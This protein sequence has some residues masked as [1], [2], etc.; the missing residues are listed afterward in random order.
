MSKPIKKRVRDEEVNIDHIDIKDTSGNIV[1]PKRRLSG[2]SMSSV[3][4]IRT[5][6]T[7]LRKQSQD[8][9]VDVVSSLDD[10]T[11]DNPPSDAQPSEKCRKL[12]ARELEQHAA[13]KEAF[14]VAKAALI[15]VEERLEIPHEG[16]G[17]SEVQSTNGGRGDEAN[18]IFV[19]DAIPAPGL[20]VSNT[21]EEWRA[22]RSYEERSRAQ[23]RTINR[24]SFLS[25]AAFSGHL[26][27]LKCAVRD[28]L[29]LPSGVTADADGCLGG[30]IDDFYRLILSLHG[31]GDLLRVVT[32]EQA[33]AHSFSTYD[34]RLEEPQAFQRLITHITATAPH[35]VEEPE[36]AVD[37]EGTHRSILQAINASLRKASS[38]RGPWIAGKM[39]EQ[40]KSI[41]WLHDWLVEFSCSS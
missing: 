7:N 19:Q 21:L 39:D 8:S 6:E 37:V 3:A 35:M 36:A 41:V 32:P 23:G 29:S 25:E 28:G 5:P 30:T 22:L 13:A 15:R 26:I 1:R 20:I 14:E 10:M 11:S 31:V 18:F 17:T 16:D 34:W 27:R 2:E 24:R 40:S 38:G 12:S 9:S 4:S 33:L